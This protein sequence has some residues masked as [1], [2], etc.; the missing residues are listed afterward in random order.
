M[1]TPRLLTSASGQAADSYSSPLNSS[2]AGLLRPLKRLLALAL[3]SALLA[4]IASP[5]AVLRPVRAEDLFALSLVSA[6]AISPNG[7]LV[8]F[9]VARMNGP[10]DR[11]DRN[12]WLVSTSGGASYPITRDGVSDSPVWAP[13][14]RLAFVR[15]VNGVPQIFAYDPSKRTTAQLTHLAAGAY[16]PIWSHDGKRIAFASVTVDRQPPAQIDFAA[17]GFTPS[18]AQRTSD[19]RQIDVERY[20]V[21]GLG[22]T[23]DKHQHLWVMRADGSHAIALTRGHRWSEDQFAW[24][25]DDARIAFTSI[26]RDSPR[27]GLSDVYT[28]PSTG[29]AMRRVSS[30]QEANVQPAYTHHTN[31]LYFFSGNVEDSAEYPAFVSIAPNERAPTALV[32]SNS[33]QWGDWVLADLKMPGAICGPLFTPSDRTIVTDISTPGSSTLIAIDRRTGL[34]TKLTDGR[35]EVADCTMSA[36]GSTIA[37]TCADFRHPAEV[38][39]LDRR[40]RRSRAL[41]A[42]NAGYLASVLLSTPQSFWITDAAGYRVQAWFMPAVGP[43]AH[44]KRPTLLDIHGGPQAE[45]GST[46]FHELQY[47]CGLG[48]NVVFVNPE[49][50]IGYGWAFEHALEGNWGPPM[51][52]DVMRVMDEVAKRPNVDPN[53]FGVLG[54]SYGGY[55]TLWVI[56]H[57]DRFKAAISERPASDLATESLDAF[58]ASSNGLGG[59]YAWGKPW[60][61]ASKNYVDSPLNDVENVHTPL[62]LLHSTQDTETPLDQTLDEFSALKQ[63]GRVVRFVE[64]P[65]ENHD[66]NRVGSPIHRVERLHIFASWFAKYLEP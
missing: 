37:Y 11:Y 10:K 62:L 56:S 13:D 18:P 51:F 29:G 24:S 63:L 33:Y 19:I 26:R 23:Y 34:V 3:A 8:A 14:D 28:I 55:A 50:S 41:T 54:G 64:V 17:A 65:S 57:T 4:P 16:D 12:V 32:P 36:D 53:R 30:P 6:P 44:G 38:C 5:G 15:S 52:D 58:F 49:G 59:E 42:L 9:V 27:V 31:R 40:T 25:P 39:V 21:N 43:R 20:E 35:G 22:Y 60:D 2:R 7:R 46:F 66:L 47:W 48:Y 61:A 45:F 1:S